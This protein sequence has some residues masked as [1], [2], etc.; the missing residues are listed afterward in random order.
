MDFI[1]AKESDLP[2]VLAL[3]R[4]VIGTGG[5]T[6]NKNYPSMENLQNDF[7]TG[8]LYVFKENDDLIGAVSLVTKNE[9]DGLDCWKI[10]DGTQREFARLVVTPQHQGKGYARELVNRVLLEFKKDGCHAVHILAAKS[11]T[12]AVKLY[13]SLGFAFCGECSR[14][15]N[16]YYACEKIL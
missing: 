6:W 3:Y 13:R 1:K 14:Y 7:Q 4:S 11:N 8:A 2:A 5:S 15:G 9:L 12:Y 10:R 16:E